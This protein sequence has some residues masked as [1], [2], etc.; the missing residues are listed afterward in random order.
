MLPVAVVAHSAQG[1]TRFKI[2]ARRRDAQY[3]A[4]VEQRLSAASDVVRVQA[5]P[6]TGSVLVHHR[7][8]HEA[9]HKYAEEQEL[10]RVSTLADRA[11][12]L[13][14]RQG[15]SLDQQLR[16]FTGGYL[17]LRSVTFIALVGIGLVQA[18]RGHLAG[19]ALTLFSDAASLLDGSNGDSSAE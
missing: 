2:A 5:N 17:D 10:F 15:R 8:S 6:V 7:G 3:F 11:G 13:L 18:I 1:R 4:I 12:N 16:E 14:R 9:L 19:P